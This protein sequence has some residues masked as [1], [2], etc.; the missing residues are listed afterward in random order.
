MQLK[1]RVRWKTEV[2]SELEPRAKPDLFKVESNILEN[3]S[4]G[5]S[6]A[7]PS[8]SRWQRVAVLRVP[9][10]R[11]NYW[12]PNTALFLSRAGESA[13]QVRH[14][15]ERQRQDSLHSPRISLRA[16]QSQTGALLQQDDVV[17]LQRIGDT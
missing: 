3:G 2:H 13:V 15:C 14:H 12:S 7:A 1:D 16:H 5:P 9:V 10:V 6:R 17:S 4:A 11:D 8:V